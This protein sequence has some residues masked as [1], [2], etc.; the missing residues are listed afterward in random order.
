MVYKPVASPAVTF[1]RFD[2]RALEQVCLSEGN[3]LQFT[4]VNHPFDCANR[5]AEHPRGA[6]GSVAYDEW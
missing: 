6:F 1:Q 5:D 2:I 4:A 3:R